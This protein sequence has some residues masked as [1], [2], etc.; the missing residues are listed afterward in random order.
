MAYPHKE[1]RRISIM[2]K[3]LSIPTPSEVEDTGDNIRYTYL[4]KAPVN[5][6][7]EAGIELAAFERAIRDEFTYD[8]CGCEH[9]CCGCTIQDADTEEKD[10]VIILTVTSGV[11]Y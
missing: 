8:N 3:M 7:K 4:I 2:G 9:D 11:N 10:G 1:A 6:L 5:D